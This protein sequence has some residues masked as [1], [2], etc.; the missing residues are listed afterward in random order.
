MVFLRG[1]AQFIKKQTHE[2]PS[3]HTVGDVASC[4]L[5]KNT[6]PRMVSS[7]VATTTRAPTGVEVAYPASRQ[8]HVVCYDPTFW[9][10]LLAALDCY[11][12]WKAAAK[13]D[14]KDP[15]VRAWTHSLDPHTTHRSL[16]PTLYSEEDAADH[17]VARFLLPATNIIQAM[18]DYDGVD[19]PSQPTL[20]ITSVSATRSQSTPDRVL[21]L[22]E[23]IKAINEIKM[24]IEFKTPNSLKK[25]DFVLL[26]RC[27]ERM[28]NE[29]KQVF[30][31]PYW[32]MN[33][34]DSLT[35]KLDKILCQVRHRNHSEYIADTNNPLSY[36][37]NCN[38]ST[39][40][41]VCCRLC[42]PI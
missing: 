22:L 20:L 5:P 2:R 35:N 8:L 25:N 28:Q 1:F 39:F 4:P 40:R 9:E 24:I 6:L 32:W 31:I 17:S 12:A 37:V 21:R 38:R 7:A 29:F 19:R 18:A 26:F 33:D 42:F 16:G 15:R 36:G 14:L 41:T 13:Q 30:P 3:N 23:L 11:D 27:F 34:L 10:R